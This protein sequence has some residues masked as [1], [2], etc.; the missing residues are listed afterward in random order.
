MISVPW[1]LRRRGLQDSRRH[2]QR[3]REAIQNNLKHLITQEAIITSNRGHRIKLPIRYLDQYRFRYGN[4]TSAP[5]G[6]GHGTGDKGD[7]VAKSPNDISPSDLPGDRPGEAIYEVEYSVE[8]LARMMLKDLDLP[9][10]DEKP[11]RQETVT[12]EQIR[13]VEKTGLWPN[14]D[15]RRTLYQNLK[16]HAAKGEA[17]L[18]P[19]ANEDLR[20]RTWAEDT[21]R[22]SQASV[23]MLMDRSGSMTTEKRY[24]AKCFF[25]WLVRFLQLKYKDVQMVFISHDTRAEVTDEE[26]FFSISNSGGTRCSSALELAYLH[27]REHHP[28]TRWNNYVFHFSDG[29]NLP[30]DNARCVELVER[31][32]TQ[33]RMVGFGEITY[34]DWASFYYSQ[35]STEERKR[36]TLFQSLEA[37]PHPRLLVVDIQRREEVYNALRAFLKGDGAVA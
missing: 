25:F 24:I 27:L 10:L 18:G 21:E 22:Q 29:D 34:R 1:D 20:F 28:P 37:I 19:L 2:D 14:I 9:W 4:D 32:L 30:G 36:G 11:E 3:V 12:N 16:R 15:K 13:H 6:V 33:A 35:S 8:E 31:L 7:L 17:R 5:S 23:Y 26:S